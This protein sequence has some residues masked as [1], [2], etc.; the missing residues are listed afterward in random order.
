[1][2]I[3]FY[4]KYITPI[5]LL[6]IIVFVLLNVFLSKEELDRF[7]ETIMDVVVF[8]ALMHFTWYGLKLYQRF[9]K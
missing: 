4:E 5:G 6:L 3:S 9:R 2:F 1:M 8:F 7:R